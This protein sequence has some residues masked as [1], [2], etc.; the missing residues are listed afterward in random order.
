[1]LEQWTSQF[2]ETPNVVM[3]ALRYLVYYGTPTKKD[4]NVLHSGTGEKYP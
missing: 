3:V 4:T 2:N 1:M